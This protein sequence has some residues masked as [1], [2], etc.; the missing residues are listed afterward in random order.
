[1]YR[2]VISKTYVEERR[3]AGYT[4]HKGNGWYVPQRDQSLGVVNGKQMCTACDLRLRVRPPP[5]ISDITIRK[6][7]S[8]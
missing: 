3:G 6:A 5:H 4:S 2:E 7:T 8:K 1:M